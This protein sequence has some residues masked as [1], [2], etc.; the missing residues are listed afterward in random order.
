MT[1]VD[2]LKAFGEALA[3]LMGEQARF[4][5]EFAALPLAM[6]AAEKFADA[7]E[8]GQ[9]IAECPCEDMP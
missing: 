6:A 7:W 2:R 9:A 3:Q 5:G 8:A 1:N 4:L